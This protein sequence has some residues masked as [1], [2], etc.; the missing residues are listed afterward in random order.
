MP[1]GGDDPLSKGPND[2]PSDQSEDDDDE[3]ELE[4]DEEDLD[5]FLREHNALDE[6]GQVIDSN[7]ISKAQEQ[8]HVA[9]DMDINQDGGNFSSHV[10]AQYLPLQQTIPLAQSST[11]L[12]STQAHTF[13]SSAPYGALANGNIHLPPANMIP[14]PQ[15]PF[16]LQDAEDWMALKQR[17]I[18]QQEILFR[19]IISASSSTQNVQ[20]PPLSLHTPQIAPTLN[21]SLRHVPRPALPHTSL[22]F[23]ETPSSDQQLQDEMAQAILGGDME[24][25]MEGDMVVSI[26]QQQQKQQREEVP[27]GQLQVPLTGLTP[28]IVTPEEMELLK[29][30]IRAQTQHA[31]N[32]NR[33]FQEAIMRH[34]VIVQEAQDRNKALQEEFR[35]L[36]AKQEEAQSNPVL[37]QTSDKGLGPPYFVDINNNVPPENEDAL[38]RKKRAL[39]LSEREAAWGRREREQ[40]REGVIAENKRILFEMFSKTKNPATI[41]FLD[42]IPESELVV[43]TKGLDWQRVAERY[44]PR[45]TPT[46]CLI[47]WTSH[48]HPGINNGIW[49]KRE[50]ALL[51]EL[52][53]KHQGRDW[54]QIALDLN[55]NRTASQCFRRYQSRQGKTITRSPWTEEENNILREAVRLLGDNNWSQVSYCLDNRSAT[56][57]HQHWTKSIC[58]TIRRVR[59]LPEEDSALRMAVEV[60]GKGK[61]AKVQHY[62]PGR[63]DIQ[64]RERYANVLAPN[65]R[66]GSWSKEESEKLMHLVDLHGVGKWALIASHMNGRTDNQCVRRWQLVKREQEKKEQGLPVKEFIRRRPGRTTAAAIPD[67][68]EHKDTIRELTKMNRPDKMAKK[69]LEKQCADARKRDATRQYHQDLEY[70]KSQTD[71]NLHL[72]R[73]RDI[74]DRWVDRWG[75]HHKPIEQVFNLGIPPDYHS[76]PTLDGPSSSQQP[77][78]LPSEQQSQQPSRLNSRQPSLE[79]QSP[80]QSVLPSQEPLEEGATESTSTTRKE[81]KNRAEGLGPAV[82]GMTKYMMMHLTKQRRRAGVD[83]MDDLS[84]LREVPPESSARPGMVRPVPPSVATV[85]ALSHLVVQGAYEGGR[86]LFPHVCKDGKLETSSLQ[87]APLTEAER[88]QPEYRELSERFESMFMWPTMMGMLHMGYA[89]ELVAKDAEK[90]RKAQRDKATR[91]RT[92]QNW[93]RWEAEQ[94][95]NGGKTDLPE[96]PRIPDSPSPS[97]S[98]PGKK[99]RRSRSTSMNTSNNESESYS[100]DDSLSDNDSD[101]DSDRDDEPAGGDGHVS[102]KRVRT[103]EPEQ[104]E[105]EEEGERMEIQ[106]DLLGE[107]FALESGEATETDDEAAQKVIDTPRSAPDTSFVGCEGDTETDSDVEMDLSPTRIRARQKAKGKTKA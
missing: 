14:L 77:S 90:K 56:Q 1:S 61:W 88:S 91:E 58:T 38:M 49:R 70:L 53:A 47:Q 74:Y 73:Q 37:L 26:Q 94:R 76:N 63:T 102:A 44:V 41:K 13:L 34:L 104:Q 92:R 81:R 16:L 30:E 17:E 85:E 75:E 86:F 42:T 19:N 6:H 71:Y 57:C 78:Q 83:T 39:G 9:M 31:L 48:D 22:S 10:E 60:F 103:E 8:S 97:A 15:E 67:T 66:F 96:P 43:N 51:E 87:V 11:T 101:D 54:I 3:E 27:L 105:Q 25:D 5:S 84:L 2:A 46:Q 36:M 29:D 93:E 79:P 69:R 55:T 7:N 21:S 64:C 4:I 24:V 80:S 32:E 106:A 107:E 59:W 23:V 52:V 28:S 12:P 95:A 40:L 100:E 72:H 33:K 82:P 99:R 68:E 18:E 20:T 35:A 50:V 89:R 98:S 45:R 65:I 62:V